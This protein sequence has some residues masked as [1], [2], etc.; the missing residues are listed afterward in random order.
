VTN[1]E[2][3][4]IST[5]CLEY[6]NGNT[7]GGQ[8]EKMGKIPLKVSFPGIQSFFPFTWIDSN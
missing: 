4:N 2:S 1:G 3:N 8:E 6:I 5:V 7:R